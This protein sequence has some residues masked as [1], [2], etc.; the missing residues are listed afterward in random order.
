MW[1]GTLQ[2]LKVSERRGLRGGQGWILQPKEGP[3]GELTQR[4]AQGK[5]CALGS[6]YGGPV[7]RSTYQS[8][9]VT[10]GC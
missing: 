5:V 2:K 4:G 9:T 1:P 6:S 10:S 7:G 3:G 8:M